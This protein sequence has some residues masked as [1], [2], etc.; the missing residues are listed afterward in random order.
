MLCDFWSDFI[1][2]Y[3][4]SVNANATEWSTDEELTLAIRNVHDRVLLL[5][6]LSDDP[7][8]LKR[9]FWHGVYADQLER[10]FGSRIRHVLRLSEKGSRGYQRDCVA[11]QSAG[12]PQQKTQ[13][14]ITLQVFCI[15]SPFRSTPHRQAKCGIADNAGS[16]RHGLDVEEVV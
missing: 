4:R 6:G 15:W 3:T 1:D 5:Q 11:N 7:N 16:Q 8:E 10:A 13:R 2:C 9:S 12:S 14:W